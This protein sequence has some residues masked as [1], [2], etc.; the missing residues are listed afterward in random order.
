M[1]KG[2]K[3]NTAIKDNPTNIS[4]IIVEVEKDGFNCK[5][6]TSAKN[7]KN[8][9][10]TFEEIQKLFAEN[11]IDIEGFE[12]N[13]NDNRLVS[14]IMDCYIKDSVINEYKTSFSDINNSKVEL[15]G[16]FSEQELLMQEREKAITEHETT[17]QEQTSYIA[18]LKQD[19]HT[20][21]LELDTIKADLDST[22]VE[23][24][25]IK[26]ELDAT[27]VELTKSNNELQATQNELATANQNLEKEKAERI[28]ERTADKEAWEKEK[29]DYENTIAGMELV[30]NQS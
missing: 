3:I 7:I 5:P 28:A 17:I 26:L 9:K 19:L 8:E 25:T 16:R 27:N 24:S 21:K 30:N 1:E 4:Y 22:K 11:T 10:Y 13:D 12:H 20:N 14:L 23:L 29:A 15:D 2:I 18:V 6:K